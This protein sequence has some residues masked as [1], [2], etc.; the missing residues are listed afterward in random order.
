MKTKINK[1]LIIFLAVVLTALLAVSAV[2]AKAPKSFSDLKTSHWCYEK[3][4]DFLGRGF[5]DGYEDG[6]FR[7]DQ[8]ITR[9]EFVKIVN[10]FFGYDS[11]PEEN[12]KSSFSDVSE[13]DWYFGYV[14]EA[15]ENGYIKGYT[16]GTFRPFE[17]IRRQEATV[18]LSR[19]LGIDKEEYPH[20]PKYFE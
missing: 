3:I 6:T 8:T 5:V 13:E 17:T 12:A 18:I 9:A 16:D 1:K 7:P 11:T 20:I 14:E 2:F 19:I 10:N 4:M 15:V